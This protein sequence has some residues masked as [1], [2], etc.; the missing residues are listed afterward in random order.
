MIIG[1][2]TITAEDYRFNISVLGYH[3]KPIGVN[4]VHH[5]VARDFIA[6][7]MDDGWI[8][9]SEYVKLVDFIE[10]ADNVTPRQRAYPAAVRLQAK[11]H[12]LVDDMA[13]NERKEVSF[14]RDSM[15]RFSIACAAEA[16]N[17]TELEQDED[18]RNAVAKDTSERG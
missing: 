8:N 12:L 6:D 4:L 7:L 14:W 9:E 11:L 17:L 13:R 15:A 16:S 10:N 5:D 1:K 3:G 2:A 18:A